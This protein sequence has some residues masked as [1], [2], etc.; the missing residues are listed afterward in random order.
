MFGMDWMKRWGCQEI[1]EIKFKVLLQSPGLNAMLCRG[2]IEEHRY[3]C[4]PGMLCKKQKICLL[5]GEPILKT[6]RWFT[7]CNDVC[8]GAAWWIGA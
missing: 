8:W 5:P 7:S 2:W 1:T 4:I 3:P 6:V